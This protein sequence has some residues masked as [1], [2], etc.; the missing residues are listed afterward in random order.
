MADNKFE[1]RLMN[2]SITDEELAG[3]TGGAVGYD[4]D[5]LNRK[6][7]EFKIGDRVIFDDEWSPFI[8]TVVG[9]NRPWYLQ[10]Q[11]DMYPDKVY[12]YPP[13]GLRKIG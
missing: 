10:L 4:E 12:S 7:D 13:E 1:E 11:P 2:I 5:A 9:Y 6:L 8:M 3:A